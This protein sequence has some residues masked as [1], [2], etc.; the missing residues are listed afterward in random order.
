MADELYAAVRFRAG[1]RCE[2]C[3]LP[4][5]ASDLSFPVD[6]VIA[7]KHR[8]RTELDNLALACQRCNAHKGSDLATVEWPSLDLIR[9][10]HP[11][12]D[13]WQDHFRFDG[14]VIV[15]LTAVGRATARLLAMN[16]P[17]RVE[18]R[19]WLIEDGLF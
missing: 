10:F 6:H 11:R 5:A 9:L 14:A 18:T 12:H 19:L 4:E 15:G 3:R 8:G 1:F 13:R 7:R 17:R 16:D 2:Y